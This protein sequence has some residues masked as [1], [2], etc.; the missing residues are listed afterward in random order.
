[1]SASIEEVFESG[2]VIVISK[3]GPQFGEAIKKRSGDRLVIDLVRLWPE[4][5][6]R[7]PNYEGIR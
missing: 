1:M 3:N 5:N 7:P 2:D 6:G 4:P